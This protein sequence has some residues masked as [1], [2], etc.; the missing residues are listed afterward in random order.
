MIINYDG[1]SPISDVRSY[2]ASGFNNGLQTGNGIISTRA[3]TSPNAGESGKTRVGFGEASSVGLSSF[4]GIA[5]DGSTILLKYTY[6][7]DAN[8]DGMVDLKDLAALASS[9]QTSGYWSNGDFNY[10]GTVNASDLG[11]LSTNWQAGTTAALGPQLSLTSMLTSFG[12]PTPV[13]EPVS[14]SMLL[15]AAAMLRRRRRA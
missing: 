10:D 3:K 9:W 4:D 5:V 1:A 11:L 12:L 2:V 15:A 6:A 7:G 8:L 13:P 14:M